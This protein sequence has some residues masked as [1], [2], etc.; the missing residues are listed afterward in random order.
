LPTLFAEPLLS[1]AW[2]IATSDT[3]EI[4]IN[5]QAERP[6]SC[7]HI[8]VGYRAWDDGKRPLAAFHGATPFIALRGIAQDMQ[9]RR[10]KLF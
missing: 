10:S 1:Q 9:T 5:N 4:A 6:F 7:Y 2:V 8:D 3:D